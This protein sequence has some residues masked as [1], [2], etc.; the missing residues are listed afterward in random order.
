MSPKLVTCSEV[1]KGASS[2]HLKKI[3]FFFGARMKDKLDHFTPC[4]CARDNDGTTH[5]LV[6][7][8][9]F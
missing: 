9:S 6:L 3:F 8:R 2:R 5:P 7:A 4:A 1:L